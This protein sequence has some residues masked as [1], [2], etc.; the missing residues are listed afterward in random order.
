[1]KKILTFLLLLIGYISF[2]QIYPSPIF[3]KPNNS[4]GIRSNRAEPDSAQY[5]PTSCG[6]PLDSTWLF[7][8][9]NNGNG[10]KPKLGALY[11]D[12]CGH[13][14]YGWD[15]SLKNWHKID[16]I[17]SGGS[18]DTAFLHGYFVRFSDSTIYYVTPTQ[19]SLKLNKTD[20]AAMLSAYL[21]AI[22]GVKY[23]DTGAMLTPYLRAI[24]GVKYSDTS[25]MLANYLRASVA[26]S[27]Y[28]PLTNPS[29]YLAG[30]VANSNLAP[31]AANTLKGN[32]TGSSAN[33]ADLT[34]SQA[35]TLLSV[36]GM[37]YRYSDSI[38]FNV[39]GIRYCVLDSAGSGGG[40]GGLTANQAGFIATPQLLT[41]RTYW[42]DN[43]WS[44]ATANNYFTSGGLTAAL[45][46]TSV[47]LRASG[48]NYT[49]YYYKNPGGQNNTNSYLEHWI[50]Y[51]TVKI[52]TV[53]SSTS[54]GIWTGIQSGYQNFGKIDLT[55]SGTTGGLLYIVANGITVAT[56][57]SKLT[58]GTLDTLETQFQ[59][60]RDTLTFRVTDKSTGSTDTV[61][62]V[63]SNAFSTVGTF[64]AHAS[65][66]YA[67]GVMG[68]TYRLIASRVVNLNF[69]NP[70]TAIVA[71]S[72]GSYYNG[73]GAGAGS[74]WNYRVSDLLI[75]AGYSCANFGGAGDVTDQVILRLQDVF[76]THPR[77][78]I[79]WFGCN[80]TRAANPLSEILYNVANVIGQER[81]HGIQPY[82][83]CTPET[84]SNASALK[85]LDSAFRVNY[86][87]IYINVYD[88][89]AS[90]T[91]LFITSDDIHLTAAGG[92]A[93]AAKTI[94][95]GKI[96]SNI[97]VPSFVPENPE[98]A[99]L[100]QVNFFRNTLSVNPTLT[101]AGLDAIDIHDSVSGSQLGTALNI[102]D[103]WNTVGAPT[104]IKYNV[105]N[106]ASATSSRLINL[107][108]NSASQF[109]VDATGN[110]YMPSTGAIICAGGT[111]VFKNSTTSFQSTASFHLFSPSGND[112]LIQLEPTSSGWGAFEV[113][114]APMV[115]STVGSNNIYF[116]PNRTVQATLFSSSGDWA[117]KTATDSNAYMHLGA[118]TTTSAPLKFTAGPLTTSPKNGFTEFDGINLWFTAG[119]TR[120]QITNQ[121]PGGGNPF[122]DATAI[123]K[124]NS[125]NTKL[126]SF[127]LSGF[128][129]ATTRTLTPQNA[130]YTIAGT[131]ISQTFGNTQTFTNSPVI[132][133]PA[134]LDNSTN[135]ASTAYVDAAVAV[136]KP[137]NLA[138]IANQTV[139]NTTTPTTLIGTSFGSNVFPA[140]FFTVGKTIHIKCQGV[141]STDLTNNAFSFSFN[142]SS[143]AGA[144]APTPQP[145]LSGA[146]YIIDLTG[147]CRST[148]TSGTI[149]LM[150][151]LLWNG[152]YTSFDIGAITVN[153]TISQTID[154]QAQWTTATTNNS[155]TS[156]NLTITTQ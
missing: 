134:P 102:T 72:K 92:G 150:G 43:S 70:V 129:T 54:Y 85:S 4:Y 148:G 154:L 52:D 33:P 32:N 5:I 153:T 15:P 61:Q 139:T 25:S 75:A 17:G 101:A 127:N 109:A 136:G 81:A 35:Q 87:D 58:F 63:M 124:N 11:W 77:Q 56:S 8:M 135:G 91:A 107:S 20:T 9:Q 112:Q 26:A 130:S 38:C 74:S 30:P 138:T 80:D 60:M 122:S 114:S 103:N 57:A 6:V 51:D 147:I 126:L 19:L 62:Y 73:V 18:L 106:T 12:S 128:T 108:V 83:I 104:G 100:G 55:N 98:L 113:V 105:V 31:M 93:V 2:A 94:S 66:Q 78:A 21:R 39:N 88:T 49:S 53:I 89:I 40:G 144:F 152:V 50:K 34:V 119:G 156:R 145:S 41:G 10:E 44:S 97:Y 110:L 14:L 149:Y 13:H 65:G 82:I 151:S 116:Y 90:N 141:V 131:N 45:N 142:T 76:S 143:G 111:Q 121:T 140:N 64:V 27:L 48:N 125:D 7:S 47:E 79:N 46:G 69:M 28:Y 3:S 86:P 16:S 120:S 67:T 118:G 42:Y 84:G 1:M 37:L 68:G 99:T 115:L 95:S 29:N 137:V 22:L 133:T 23:T 36:P 146:S 155:I 59:Q 123:L 96:I 24:L 132:P 117:I 71:D